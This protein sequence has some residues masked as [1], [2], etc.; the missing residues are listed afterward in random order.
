MSEHH[1][2]FWASFFG[3]ST[4][5]LNHAGISIVVHAKLAGYCGVWFFKH[6]DRLIVSTPEG[7]LEHL[8]KLEG[9]LEHQLFATESF[10][11]KVFGSFFGR[12]I[13]P[14]YHGGLEPT[15]FRPVFSS[16]VRALS[17]H[18]VETRAVFEKECGLEAWEDSGLG[19]ATYHLVAYFEHERITAMAEFRSW[20][21]TAGDPC[22][23]VRQDFRARGLGAMV[24][25]E[26]IRLALLENNL[27]E[28]KL[29][30]YQTL[31]SNLTAVRLARK[32]GYRQYASHLAVRLTSNMP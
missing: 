19:E 26:V 9:V 3:V 12:S 24:V 11:K 20:N 4:S 28:N 29:P 21:D 25:S 16:R 15:D 1:D 5:D 27:L 32:L 10:L 2:Q 23:L 31:E 22:V 13:G 30:L 14:A 7:W 17:D 18:D 6:A 8:Q